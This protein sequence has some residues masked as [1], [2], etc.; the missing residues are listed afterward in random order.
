MSD[1][2]AI[3]T[4]YRD[5][6][7]RGSDYVY[8]DDE[9]G[10]TA[11]ATGAVTQATSKSTGVTLNKSVGT[12]TMNNAALAAST[13]VV[14][15]M[16]NSKV[17]VNDAVIVNVVSGPVTD[18]TYNAFVAGIAAGSAKIALRNI[19]AGSLSEA[20]VLNFVIVHGGA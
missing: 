9:L 5:Q 14:F 20:V 1:S 17:G 2:Q 7:L 8:C 16:T 12:I 3:G 18:G 6:N 4:A 10:Y 13:T 19:S 15:T 11:N